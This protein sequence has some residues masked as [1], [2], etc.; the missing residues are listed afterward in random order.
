MMEAMGGKDICLLK[1]HGITVTGTTVEET[2]VRALNFDVLA[3]I[4][5]QVARTGKKTTAIP[6]EDVEELPDLG[7]RFNDEWVWRQHVKLL[8]EGETSSSYW[9]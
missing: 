1:G 2:T 3:R 9:R 6:R 7:A 4:T 8:E 5:L